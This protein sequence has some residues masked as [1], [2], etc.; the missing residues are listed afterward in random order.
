MATRK[1]PTFQGISAEVAA[2]LQL[3]N[4]SLTMRLDSID[5]KID[6]QNEMIEERMKP[7]SDHEQRLRDLE[8]AISALKVKYDLLTGGSLAASIAAVFKAIIGG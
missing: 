8:A 7:I 6:H 1:N 2:E 5:A 3:L 4:T